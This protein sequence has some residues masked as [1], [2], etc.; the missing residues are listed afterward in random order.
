MNMWLSCPS[1]TVHTITLHTVH[2][3]CNSRVNKS[4]RAAPKQS[5]VLLLGLHVRREE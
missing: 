5:R 2:T 3:S 1:H 4:V